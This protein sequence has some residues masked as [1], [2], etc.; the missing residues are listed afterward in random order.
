M[1]FRGLMA[2]GAILMA[3][4]FGGGV[5]AEVTLRL[6]RLAPTQGLVAT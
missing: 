4:L 2:K 6:F 1:S 5:L 3:S